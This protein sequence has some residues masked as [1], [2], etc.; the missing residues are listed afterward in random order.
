MDG[1]CLMDSHNVEYYRYIIKKL[2]IH[3]IPIPRAMTFSYFDE[4]NFL[5]DVRNEELR[6]GVTPNTHSYFLQIIPLLYKTWFYYRLPRIKTTN[7][8]YY[9]V[10]R[11]SQVVIIS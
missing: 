9:I 7:K 5:G 3:F 11:H 1:W 6:E 10:N 4:L 8:P 2:H